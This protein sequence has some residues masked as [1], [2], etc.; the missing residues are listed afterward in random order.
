VADGRLD[1]LV[2]GLTV[3]ALDGEGWNAVMF[4]ERRRDFIL[5][6][7]W[8][9]GAEPDIGSAG[10]ECLHQIGGFGRHVEAGCDA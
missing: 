5:R 6:T 9:G 7:Q 2:V 10:L 1:V 3:F 4:D 8:I